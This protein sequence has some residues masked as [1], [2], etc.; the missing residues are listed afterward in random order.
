[1]STPTTPTS[2]PRP[3]PSS[4]LNHYPLHQAVPL[5]RLQKISAIAS[6][7]AAQIIELCSPTVN[8]T[9]VFTARRHPIPPLPAQNTLETPSRAF[10]Q[11]TLR[12][13]VSRDTSTTMPHLDLGLPVQIPPVF[14]SL[15]MPRRPQQR[16][17]PHFAARLET[18]QQQE[19]EEPSPTRPRRATDLPE[20]L[21]WS[22]RMPPSRTGPSARTVSA[23][24]PQTTSF[25]LLLRDSTTPPPLS[26]RNSNTPPPL[27]PRNSNTP[28]PLKRAIYSSQETPIQKI[29]S[30]IGGILTVL[31]VAFP[32][33]NNELL[34]LNPGIA[35]S[36]ELAQKILNQMN[37]H[38][39]QGDLE[40]SKADICK[41]INISDW[42]TLVAKI[43]NAT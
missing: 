7:V 8:E 23:P 28:P 2:P 22:D 27:S 31:T 26:P 17:T 14:G 9:F 13:S 25:Q 24:N 36:K 33:F 4:N 43:S 40:A 6:K 38:T 20:P 19:T 10:S 1:M 5:T 34:S 3:A 11:L 18:L 37:L 35:N 41:A 42:N 16:L 21:L 32:T 39:N 30:A 29:E 15:L 12:P